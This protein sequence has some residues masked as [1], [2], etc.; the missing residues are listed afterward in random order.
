MLVI[1]VTVTLYAV[2]VPVYRVIVGNLFF[3][4]TAEK[5]QQARDCGF[6][7][8]ID[9]ED[10]GHLEKELARIADIQATYADEGAKWFRLNKKPKRD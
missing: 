4:Y 8:L 9:P 5:I 3:R 7:P 10:E 1:G 2:M 6:P